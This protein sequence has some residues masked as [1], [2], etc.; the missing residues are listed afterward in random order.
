MGYIL[1]QITLFVYILATGGYIV[2]F[3]SQRD[4]VRTAARWILIGSGVLHTLYLIVRYLEAGH[5][6]LTNHHEAVSFFAWSMT[7]GYL[8][9]HWR[10]NV[11]N[12]GSFVSPLIT[13]LML[14]A[15]F[16]S[17]EIIPLPPALKS[18]WLPVHASIAIMA[19]G[20]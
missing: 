17:R 1:F 18:A 6:P 3:W 15:T 16:S 9:F 10:Y 5:T 12:F 2:Y 20:T 13:I 8:T 11:R 14:I 4:D 7:W 19:N